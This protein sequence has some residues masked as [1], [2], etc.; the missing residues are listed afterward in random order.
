VPGDRFNE[1]VQSEFGEVIS[2]R[3]SKNRATK[4]QWSSRR[5][6]SGTWLV[7]CDFKTPAGQQSALWSFELRKLV[8]TPENDAAYQLQSQA[9]LTA[10]PVPP[11]PRTGLADDPLN[12]TGVITPVTTPAKPVVKDATK[13]ASQ[14][15]KSEPVKLVTSSPDSEPNDEKAD[16][17][18]PIEENL[19]TT[20]D[21]TDI[22]RKRAAETPA[23]NTPDAE[24]PLAP[25]TE[26]ISTV[27]ESDDIPAT[28]PVEKVSPAAK[29]EPKVKTSKNQIVDQDATQPIEPAPKKGRVPVQSWEEILLST[30]SDDDQAN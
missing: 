12:A 10:K 16:D 11:A 25:V 2:E 23:T 7:Q 15:V 14:P 20:T 17:A 1:P 27:D 26:I 22:L 24:K 6:E 19:A 3:L 13:P 28:E 8:L 4:V 5:D 18:A 21:L 29:K 9:P 30:R